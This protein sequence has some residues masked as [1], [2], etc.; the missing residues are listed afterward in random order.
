MFPRCKGSLASRAE[1]TRP[2]SESELLPLI[3]KQPEGDVLAEHA[4]RRLPGDLPAAVEP[5][6]LAA[7]DKAHVTKKRQKERGV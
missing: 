5:S 1:R 7:F 2:G 3:G 6:P 4:D